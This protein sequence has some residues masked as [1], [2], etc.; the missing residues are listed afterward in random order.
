MLHDFHNIKHYKHDFLR[1]LLTFIAIKKNRFTRTT[2][3]NCRFIALKLK[4]KYLYS[5]LC[6]LSS[7]CVTNR[8][9]YNLSIVITPFNKA[10]NT[11]IRTWKRVFN[12]KH[13]P[14]SQSN[15][16]VWTVTT[17]IIS[18]LF[19]SHQLSPPI[20]AA[21]CAVAMFCDESKWKG[22]DK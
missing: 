12:I 7:T 18:R 3:K 4:I 13:S 17:P 11:T 2:E 22:I 5:I 8:M 16:D 1:Q 15:D 9:I 10:L 20:L 6:Q 19:T 14:G 21:L